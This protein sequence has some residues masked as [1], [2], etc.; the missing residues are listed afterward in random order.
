VTWG[1]D[2][3]TGGKEDRKG[4]EKGKGRGNFVPNGHF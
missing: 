1:G 3:E 2:L 4:D